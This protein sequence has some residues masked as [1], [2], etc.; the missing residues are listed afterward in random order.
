MNKLIITLLVF[1]LFLPF[2]YSDSL[3]STFGITLFENN[4][5]QTLH[6]QLLAKGYTPADFMVNPESNDTGLFD[7]T[8]KRYADEKEEKAVL[9]GTMN[10]SEIVE[11]KLRTSEE[12]NSLVDI[13]EESPEFQEI[14]NDFSKKGLSRLENY[15]INEDYYSLDVYYVDTGGDEKA[16]V[17]AV[18]EG[19]Q[20]KEIRFAE[21][22]K[23]PW[24]FWISAV[25]ISIIVA[26][27]IYLR[28]KSET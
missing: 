22:G 4:K 21:K 6:G 12:L 2:S 28:K 9:S 1:T 18:F 11:I 8:Y 7:Y 24:W 19:Y 25:A 5:F 20:L 15:D 17:N 26:L 27:V 3:P 23:M 10:N 13:L 14:D 16:R